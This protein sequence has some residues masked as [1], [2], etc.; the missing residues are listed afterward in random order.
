MIQEIF[1]VITVL[2]DQ[3]SNKLSSFDIRSLKDQHMLY[4]VLINCNKAKGPYI[5]VN[6]NKVDKQLT[7]RSRSRTEDIRSKVIKRLKV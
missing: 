2:N 4:E 7:V 6:H 3:I 1:Q 5:L